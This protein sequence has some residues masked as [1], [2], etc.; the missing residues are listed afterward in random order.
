[1]SRRAIYYAAAAALLMAMLME[2]KAMYTR[3]Q[4][5]DKFYAA[6]QK[7]G[8]KLN[9]FKIWILAALASYESGD[10]NGNVFSKTN[11]LFSLTAGKY[12][13]G[14]TYKASTGYVFRVYPTWEASI[15]DF[16]KLL[17]GWPTNY[18]AATAA[19]QKGDM[20]A[21]AQALQKGGYG[22]PGKE[23]YAAELMAR[24]KSLG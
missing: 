5:K 3:A 12:W 21:F 6:A 2:G 19:A 7:V 11:N 15:E 1:M 10:G 9:G 24:A 17:T 13:T 14:P 8:V 23:T 22:D 18:G 4:F 20:V 16:V